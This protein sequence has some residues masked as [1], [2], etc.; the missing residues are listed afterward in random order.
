MKLYVKVI[1]AIISLLALV[2]LD[3]N[4]KSLL[5]TIPKPL[6][7]IMG[8]CWVASIVLVFSKPKRDELEK[9][10]K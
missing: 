6:A 5:D 10:E 1:L 7:F 2:S 8:G 3:Y 9:E 4:L